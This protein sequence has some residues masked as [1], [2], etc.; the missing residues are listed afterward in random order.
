[1]TAITVRFKQRETSMPIF[2]LQIQ[3]TATVAALRAMVQE[4]LETEDHCLM[5]LF[6]RWHVELASE[7]G[8][9]RFVELTEADEGESLTSLG[10]DDYSEVMLEGPLAGGGA[11][12]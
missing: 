1:M 10:V 8:R 7:G 2:E 3:P 4:R 9:R 11:T 6:S 12:S 5:R